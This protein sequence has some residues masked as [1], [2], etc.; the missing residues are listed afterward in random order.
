MGTPASS[1]DNSSKDNK[2]V[3]SNNLYDA[4]AG[5]NKIN[6]VSN[7]FIDEAKENIEAE[8]KAKHA[9][10]KIKLLK[11]KCKTTNRGTIT[12]FFKA[13]QCKRPHGSAFENKMD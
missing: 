9:A 13:E 7:S 4:T 8:I 2:Y 12:A 5:N 11:S 3:Y 6:N 1:K 10:N